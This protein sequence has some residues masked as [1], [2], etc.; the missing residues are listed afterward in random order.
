MRTYSIDEFYDERGRLLTA[1]SKPIARK[2]RFPANAHLHGSYAHCH[3]GAH[4][5][6]KHVIAEASLR[7]PAALEREVAEAAQP[8]AKR[9]LATPA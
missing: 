7:A 2:S 6:H 5:P 4:A 8:R 9:R 1:P 3:P